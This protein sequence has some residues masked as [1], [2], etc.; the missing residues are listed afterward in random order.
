MDT[1]N[2]VVGGGQDKQ[3]SNAPAANSDGGEQ[4]DYGDKGKISLPS[5]L[6]FLLSA[7]A[8]SPCKSGKTSQLT[9]KK[10]PTAAEYANKTFMGDKLSGEQR[11]KI[12]DTGREGIEKVTG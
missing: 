3:Q 6:S 9:K 4:Q 2:K 10:L 1:I 7:L 11:E 8:P 5:F 12:T